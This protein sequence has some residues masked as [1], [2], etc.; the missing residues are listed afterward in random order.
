MRLASLR[1]D[2][3]FRRY[4]ELAIESRDQIAPLDPL[5]LKKKFSLVKGD[6]MPGY[7]QQDCFEFLIHFLD[8]LDN[9]IRLCAFWACL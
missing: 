2:C 6:L 4:L 8:A 9:D 7:G 1:T 5:H 3:V